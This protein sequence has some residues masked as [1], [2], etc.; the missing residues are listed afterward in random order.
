MDVR[1]LGYVVIESTDPEKW[2][3]FG[4][5]VVGLMEAPGMPDDGSIYLKMD[6]R[7]F[8][9]AITKGESDRLVLCGWEL[10]DEADFEGAKSALKDAG[11]SFDEGSEADAQARKVRGL[12]TVKDPAGNTLELYWGAD[13]DYAKFVSPLGIA[14]FETG[15]NGDMGFGHCVLPAPNLEETHAFY[16]GV[17]GFGDTDYMHFKFSDD[18]ADPGMG[19]NFMHVNNPRHHS[20]ALYQAP[21]PSG[22]VHL[23]VEVANIDEV[24]YCMDRVNEREIP[25]ISSLGRHTNDRM[26]S[27]YMATPGGFALEFGC[28]GLQMDWSDYTPTVS[29]L[30]SFWGHKFAG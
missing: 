9:F 28:D 25:I 16:K 5:E 11:I 10:M 12:I 4:T 23:M 21:M 20:L 27:F 19:L 26:L 30:P 29:T 13:L 8:R 14:E 6:A 22:C 24:G 18:P 1:S 2:R 15:F 17:L 3:E 7:P